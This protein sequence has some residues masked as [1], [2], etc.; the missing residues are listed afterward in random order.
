MKKEEREALVA[1]CRASGMSAKEWCRL[2]GIEYRKYCHWATMVNREA[3]QREEDQWVALT[4]TKETDSRKPI[5]I[6]CG[7]MTIRLEPGFDPT[8]SPVNGWLAHRPA[9]RIRRNHRQG[10]LVDNKRFKA[11]EKTIQKYTAIITDFSGNTAVFL[12]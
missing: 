5:Q 7:N 12:V 3:R 9:K 6:D 4:V 10:F 11:K 2:K 1:E 8:L